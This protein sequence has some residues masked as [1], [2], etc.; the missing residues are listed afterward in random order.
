M[1]NKRSKKNSNDYKK[2]PENKNKTLN[3]KKDNKKQENEYRM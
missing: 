2:A 1:P 3:R